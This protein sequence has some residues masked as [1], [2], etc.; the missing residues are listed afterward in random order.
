MR[1]WKVYDDVTIVAN[2]EYYPPAGH[3]GS[4]VKI[5]VDWIRMG[6][7]AQINANTVVAGMGN[8]TMGEYSTVGYNCTILTG[9]DV[10]FL[11]NDYAPDKDRTV[12]RGSVDIGDG[13]CIGSNAVI[14]VNKKNQYLSIGD[15]SLIY[16]GTYIGK[17]IP[18]RSKAWSYFDPVEMRHKLAVVNRF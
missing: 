11:R 14:A 7:G 8:F 12:V 9:N 3:I 5:F 6:V 18:N 17:S 15:N 10:G 13:V 2:R 1:G 4:G 16:A